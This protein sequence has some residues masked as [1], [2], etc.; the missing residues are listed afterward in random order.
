MSNLTSLI[1]SSGGGG[2]SGSGSAVGGGNNTYTNI[3]DFIATVNAGTKTITIA[4][5]PFNLEEKHVVAGSIKIIDTTTG[6][7]T[8]AV[9]TSV[10]VS[11]GVVTLGNLST[12]FLSTDTLFVTLIGPDKA[13]DTGLDV[14]K[15]AIQN[16][17]HAH[18]TAIN[19]IIDELNVSAGTTR[20]EV[21]AESFKYHALYLAGSGG[22]TFT[23][24]AALDPSATTASDAGWKDISDIV[25]GV[26]SLVDSADV[27]FIDT[28]MMPEKF[29]I[30]YVTTDSTNAV[31]A[32]WRKY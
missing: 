18:F 27:Y 10:S 3:E 21:Q 28:P 30:K 9:L 20:V 12:N 32:F 26:A 7:V 19:H 23:I 31:D 1:A 15:S 22:V 13:Y 14:G 5:L 4:G 25:M 24:W 2:S 8:T 11:V 17:E 16:P 6:A 29:M